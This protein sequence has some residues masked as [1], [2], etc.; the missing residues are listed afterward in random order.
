[1]HNPL[2]LLFLFNKDT[3]FIMKIKPTK[4]KKR[5]ELLGGAKHRKGTVYRGKY[6]DYGDEGQVNKIKVKVKHKGRVRL[7]PLAEK[8]FWKGGGKTGLSPILKAVMRIT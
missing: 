2:T 4:R 5:S 3:N 7:V 1:M 6:I 8:M